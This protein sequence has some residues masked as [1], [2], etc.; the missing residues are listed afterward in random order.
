LDARRNRVQKTEKKARSGTIGSDDGLEKRSV[1]L[2]GRA[3]CGEP[4]AVWSGPPPGRPVSI[5][6]WVLYVFRSTRVADYGAA[7]RRPGRL[8][9][10]REDSWDAP[11]E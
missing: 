9:I 6:L 2:A 3:E 5:L 1:Y 4:A 10:T 7:S 8:T 11:S